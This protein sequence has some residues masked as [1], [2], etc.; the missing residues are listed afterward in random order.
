MVA[1]AC[2][3]ST[4]GGEWIPWGQKF[5]ISLSHMVKFCLYKKYKNVPNVVAYACNPNHLGGL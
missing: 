3:P 2:N 1:H 5:K 4:F